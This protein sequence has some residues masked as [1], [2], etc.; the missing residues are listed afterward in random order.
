VALFVAVA[1]WL[2][3]GLLV[4]AYGLVS[5]G[6]LPGGGARFQ[7]LNV[8]G[9]VSLTLNSAY[10]GAWPSAALNIVW[11]MVGAATLLRRRL[12]RESEIS[13]S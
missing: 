4:L 11:L 8:A 6:R 10:H 9:A 2:G 3:A 1:G 5:A 12:P 13:A 7:L